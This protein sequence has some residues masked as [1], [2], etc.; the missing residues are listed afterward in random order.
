MIRWD[1]INPVSDSVTTMM[2]RAYVGIEYPPLPVL[3]LCQT[4]ACWRGVAPGNPSNLPV[5]S[6]EKPA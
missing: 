3:M 5:C 2:L 1:N 6:C 4:C